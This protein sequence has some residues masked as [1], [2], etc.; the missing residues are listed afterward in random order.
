MTYN[1][2]C[3]IYQW[4]HFILIYVPT[5]FGDC[6]LCKSWSAFTYCLIKT[7]GGGGISEM[8]TNDYGGGGGG[9]PHDDISKSNFFHKMK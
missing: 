3:D 6:N 9:W 7:D 2:S 1:K 4:Y 8:L 5:K